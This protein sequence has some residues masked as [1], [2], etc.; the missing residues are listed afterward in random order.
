MKK[1]LVALFLV[2]GLTAFS[3]VTVV[4]DNS[5]LHRVLLGKQEVHGVMFAEYDCIID[6]V[7][8][9]T[10]YYLTLRNCKYKHINEEF[11]IAFEGKNTANDLYEIFKGMRTDENE[12]RYK[13]GTTP[14]VYMTLGTT[15]ISLVYVNK[16]ALIIELNDMDWGVISYDRLDELFP[17]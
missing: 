10:T 8:G 17:R 14:R 1:L 11:S 3:Q 15:K 16:K 13:S 7:V 2:I 9:D 12:K 5:N 6:E 4:S